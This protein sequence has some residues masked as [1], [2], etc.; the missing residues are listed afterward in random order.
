MAGSM[1][2]M[3]VSS[4]VA[5][6][7]ASLAIVL[8]A[9]GARGQDGPS[10]TQLL[11]DFNHFV[12]IHNYEMAAANARA[13]LAMEMSP[14]RFLAIVEDSPTMQQRFDRAYDRAL[15]VPE[16]EGLAAGLWGLYE[17][18]RRRQARSPQAI[19][20][21]IELLGGGL[22]EQMFARNLLLQ[23]R[24]YAVPQLLDVLL[25]GDDVKQRA[26]ARTILAEMGRP[27][28]V[29]L[30]EALN[31][32]DPASQATVCGVLG[33]IGYPVAVPYLYEVYTRTSTAQVRE[34]AESAIRRIAGFFDASASV[35]GLYRELADD[36]FGDRNRGTL[37]TFP[38]EQHQ[39]LWTYVRGAGLTPTAIYSELFHEARTM[40]LCERSLE[41]DRSD[42]VT[43]ALWIA[44]NFAR[45]IEQ[46]EGYDNPAYGPDRREPMYYAVAAG[47]PPTMRVLS[48]SLRERETVL[49]RRAI[50]ALARITGGSALV[51]GLA[52]ERPLVDALSYPD[53]RVQYDAALA[54]G[55][56]F[57]TRGFLGAERVVP[58]LAGLIGD[59]GTRYALVIAADVRQQQDLRVVLEGQGYTVLAPATSL[60]GA[61]EAISRA[62]VIDLIVLA[63]GGRTDETVEEIRRSPRL[64][65][66]PVLAMIPWSEVTLKRARY[67]DD[68]LTRLVRESLSADELAVSV[69]QL[70]ERASGAPVSDEE[71][72]AY[73]MASLDVLRSLAIGGNEVLDIREASSA[74]IAT[75]GET[76]G[77]V[78]LRVA[79][80]MAHIPARRVQVALMDAALS[81]GGAE[82]VSLLGSVADSAKRHGNLLE[83]VQVRRL[84][85]LAGSD[86]DS[87]ATAAAALMG[88]L[89]LPNDEL[90]PLI[91]GSD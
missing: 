5:A 43:L 4:V 2:R 80:V 83:G 65:A 63:A 74:L 11:E 54:I 22:R 9:P 58:I 85:E 17:E 49:S 61:S 73:A 40:E 91:I 79:E 45:E 60:S 24:E 48:R 32:L 89:G 31:Y 81:A 6:L 20:D 7:V 69:G 66:S 37:M 55:R 90:V 16:L 88:A 64:S 36:Y 38:G 14:E 30:V 34:A 29:V 46:P 72:R 71:A 42:P 27:A 26:N 25:R 68:H 86:D 77:D 53:R 21:N 28:A 76:S 3:S 52:D 39:L 87:T 44:A 19:D 33:E 84:I 56:A 47:T 13:L 15:Q 10:A 62:P 51:G 75:L 1:R 8:A 41:L 23:A 12:Y 50:A 18:G 67:S 35:A 78:R 70:V 57:P 82:R 59:A